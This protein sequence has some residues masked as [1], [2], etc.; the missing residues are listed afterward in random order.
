MDSTLC[1]FVLKD[2]SITSDELVM[3]LRIGKTEHKMG[4]GCPGRHIG[5]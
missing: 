2:L 5:G 1:T 3:Y 4:S